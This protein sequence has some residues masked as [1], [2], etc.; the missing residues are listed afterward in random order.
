MSNIQYHNI[1]FQWQSQT[2]ICIR[3]FLNTQFLIE[4]KQTETD[5]D[6]SSTTGESLVP[7]ISNY[8]PYL[9]ETKHI[10][11]TSENCITWGRL[12]NRRN[13]LFAYTSVA[14]ATAISTK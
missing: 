5:I 13:K 12:S 8:R 9:G 10:F 11:I 1:Y 7:N 2:N 6:V 4:R 3:I 14:M